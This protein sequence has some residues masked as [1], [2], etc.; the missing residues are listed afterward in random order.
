MKNLKKNFAEI[1]RYPSA[2]FGLFIIVL[3][4]GL[5]IYAVAKIPYS[6][7]VRLWRG[8][9]DVWY[10][11]PKTVPPAWFNAFRKTKLPESFAVKSG[12]EDFSKT[13]TPSSP[14]TS[15]IDFEYAFDFNYDVYPQE[16]MLYFNSTYQSKNPFVSIYL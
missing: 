14:D 12:E 11:N 4:V 7:A 6:E 9:E 15:A 3:L 2:V 13:V 8:G 10:M 5:A 16:M 1:S